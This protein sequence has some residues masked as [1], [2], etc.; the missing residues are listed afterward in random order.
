MNVRPAI[1]VIL[2]GAVLLSIS[3]AT[4]VAA[5]TPEASPPVDLD[6]AARSFAFHPAETGFGSF[7]AP[8][9]DAGGSAEMTALLANTG[10]VNQDLLTYPANAY[11]AASGNGG[12]EAALYGSPIAGVATWLNYEA[13]TYVLGPGEGVEITF[14]VTVP[15]ET[16]PGQY[17][18]AV[19]G[20]PAESSTVQGAGAF[21]QTTRFVTPVFILVPG[22]TDT[23]FE[24][25][26][27]SLY[28]NDEVLLVDVGIRNTGDIRVQPYGTV[29]I[30]DGAGELVVSLP[31]Q[32]ESV[33]ARESTVLTLGAA[34]VLPSGDYRI[35]V[36]FTDPDTGAAASAESGDIAFSSEATP[37]STTF[38]ITSATVMPAP[39]AHEVQF[40]NVE[41]TI[42]N[43]GDPVANAQ[44]SLIASVNG[45]EVE[46]FPISQALSLQSGDTPVS[47]RYIPVTGWSSGE[48]TFELL[49]E[50]VEPS[51]AAVVVGRQPVEGTITIP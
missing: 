33:Y 27:I 10:S 44:L 24:I 14:T 47:T 38:S 39:S 4:P 23:G 32:M 18:A 49:L 43:T 16:E 42:A 8:I 48:W 5:Q 11:T 21:Q 35:R 34:G 13:R 30:I 41:A 20:E 26:D 37:V 31:V 19:A 3:I 1:V 45:A 7:F 50:T 51:G 25:G 2:I 15:A 22:E 6:R 12:F 40:A 28:S 36:D 46:R 9:I 17:I 29:E